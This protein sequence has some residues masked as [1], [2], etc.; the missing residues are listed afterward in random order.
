M[1]P[2]LVVRAIIEIEKGRILLLRRADIVCRG[3]Y[4]LPGGKV[5]GRSL[6]QAIIDKLREETGLR[7]EPTDLSYIGSKDAKDPNTS[8]PWTIHYFYIKLS[9]QPEI[10]LNEESSESDFF[11]KGKISELELAFKSDKEI[12]KEF[13]SGVFSL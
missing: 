7:F 2:K 12:I 1:E 11:D 5:E 13:Y 9:Y 3:M 6:E 10:V 8:D 4:N